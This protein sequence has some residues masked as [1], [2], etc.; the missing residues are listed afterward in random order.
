MPASIVRSKAMLRGVID[1]DRCETL[2]DGA[3]VQEDGVIVEVS[4]FDALVRRFPTLPVLG[5]DT[6]I[7]APGFVNA[8]HHVG[9]TPVQLGVPDLPLELWVIARMAAR[10]VDPYLDTLYSAFEMI[11]SGVTTVQHIHDSVEGDLNSVKAR[12]DS[13][14]RAYRDVGMRA[15]ISYGIADQN[16]FVHR[17]DQEFLATLP[18]DLRRAASDILARSKVGLEDGIALFK[19]LHDEHRDSR[20]IRVQL[21]PANLHWCSDEAL[22]ALSL[23]AH[24]YGVPL[25]MHLLE[26]KFQ[27]DYARARFGMSAFAYLERFGLQGPHMTI[28]HGVWMTPADIARAAETD[29]SVCHNCSSNLRLRSGLAP[30]NALENAGVNVAIGID[31]AGL[32]DDRDMLQELRLVRNLH[33]SPGLDDSVPGTGQIFRMATTGGARTT[34]F[35]GSIGSIQVGKAADIVLFDWRRISYP[36]LDQAT[37][38]ADAVLHRAKSQDVRLVMCDGEVIYE[39][40]MFQR[41]DQSAALAELH[42]L[43]TAS[44]SSDEHERR[45][46]SD[47][48]RHH[49]RRFLLAHGDEEASILS[50]RADEMAGGR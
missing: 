34:P 17:S 43:M 14:A 35:A 42:R 5:R 25:H 26:T 40:G 37:P 7:A 50:P 11:S 30:L 28:G 29:T 18:A 12:L 48:L 24:D 2:A 23:T 36:Y 27:R 47:D 8:H 1:R 13:V 33:R 6:D 41:V 31:E 46:L 20:R 9:L 10:D 32:N 21:A 15:S 19:S 39:D 38:S 44:L 4:T 22:Q 16:H 3:L 49:V 45:R